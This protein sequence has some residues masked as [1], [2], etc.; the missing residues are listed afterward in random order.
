MPSFDAVSEVDLQE[1]MNAI[2]QTAREVGNRFDFKGS[3]A[4]VSNKENQI[5]VKADN[6]FQLGQVK[7]ILNLK[8]AKRGIDILS[9]KA[10]KVEA[11]NNQVRQTIEVQ[12]GINQD[13]SRKIVKLIKEK[14][15]KVQASIQGEKV[16]VTGKKRDDLQNVIGLLN[17]SKLD[18]PLQFIN[19]RD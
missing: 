12:Q 16:R 4:G 14:K 18:V 7:D 2:D 17:D 6:E 9:L 3:S 10:G 1:V 15:L 5:T 8:L 11:G 19:F 13:T